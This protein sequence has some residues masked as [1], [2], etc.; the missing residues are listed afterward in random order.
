MK[1]LTLAALFAVCTMAVVLAIPAKPGAVSYV[2]SD[3]T[4]ITLETFGDEF[5]H[6][7][8]MDKTYTV[9]QKGSGD[10]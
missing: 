7:T 8:L 1:K 6:Y 3:G 2:Q 5:M 10:F 9:V 4:V